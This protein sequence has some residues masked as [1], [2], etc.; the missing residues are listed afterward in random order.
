MHHAPQ[1]VSQE[2]IDRAQHGWSAFTRGMTWSTIA[3]A[4]IVALVVAILA[5]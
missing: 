2:A 5:Y 3:T 1:N 4:V